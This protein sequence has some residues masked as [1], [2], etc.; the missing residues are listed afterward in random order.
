MKRL[1]DEA[2]KFAE[3]LETMLPAEGQIPDDRLP[4]SELAKCE[5]LI[6]TSVWKAGI[7]VGFESGHGL[8][9]SKLPSS[10]TGWSAPLLLGVAAGTLGATLGVSKVDSVS[11]MC[12]K[13]SYRCHKI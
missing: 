1:E 4:R 7:G 11:K 2:A 9:I 12:H 6:F 13:M 10:P 3:V 5:G 8:L